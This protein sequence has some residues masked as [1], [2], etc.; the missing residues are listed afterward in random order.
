MV[1]KRCHEFVTFSYPGADKGP[2]T[3]VSSLETYF[4]LMNVS[5]RSVFNCYFVW[6]SVSELSIFNA[7]TSVVWAH[8][9]N[10]K[11]NQ[12]ILCDLGLSPVSPGRITRGSE[13]FPLCCLFSLALGGHVG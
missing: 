13:N 3:D 10:G 9:I 12:F 6:T 2:D 8:T 11:T 1:H 4:I 5:E 7:C